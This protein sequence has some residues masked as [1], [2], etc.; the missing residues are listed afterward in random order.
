MTAI[1]RKNSK[2]R[3][4][5]GLGQILLLATVCADAEAE[6]DEQTQLSG[7]G[8]EERGCCWWICVLQSRAKWITASPIKCVFPEPG[9]P[10]TIVSWCPRQ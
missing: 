2:F 4:D 10:H 1:T 8:L 3:G 5:G 9:G 6:G 7:D